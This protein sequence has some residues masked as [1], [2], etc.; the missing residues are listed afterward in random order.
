MNIVRTLISLIRNKDITSCPNEQH[1][2]F[3]L[4]HLLEVF[5]SVIFGHGGGGDF[6]HKC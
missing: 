3:N 5:Y 1:D 6:H 4:V 2:F